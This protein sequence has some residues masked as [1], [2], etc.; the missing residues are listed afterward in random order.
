MKGL[1]PFLWIDVPGCELSIE[2]KEILS[3]PAIFGV[4]LFTKNFASIP[5]LRALTQSIKAIAPHLIITVDQEG[6]RV[7]RFKTGFTQ[8]P[9]MS[10]WGQLCSEGVPDDVSEF[11]KTIVQMVSEL[12]AVGIDTNLA[13]VLDLDYGR[14][15]IIGERSFGARPQIVTSLANIFVDQMHQLNMPVVGKHFPGHGWVKA[16]SHEALPIDERDW[17]TILKHDLQPFTA[18]SEKLDAVMPAHIVYSQ[19]DDLPAGFSRFWLQTVLREK[20]G[21]NGLIVTDDLTMQG[22]AAYGDYVTR[23]EMALD[24]G[25]DVLTVCN[26]CLGVI[27]ILDSIQPL[28][29]DNFLQK[30]AGYKRYLYSY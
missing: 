22:A 1:Q 13:P 16:D 20:L 15:D 10:H 25:A 5:Q 29:C 30:V 6:G 14:S 3:H 28:V 23:A 12:R 19:L 9:P 21:F 17:E 27:Q 18:L 2:D 26:N 7:Q 24:A 11:K 4:V 8:L